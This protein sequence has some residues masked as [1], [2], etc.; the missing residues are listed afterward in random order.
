MT[1]PKTTF[2]KQFALL[3]AL[4]TAIALT[5]NAAEKPPENEGE[6][7]AVYLLKQL[8]EREQRAY[9]KYE[10][11]VEENDVNQ[12]RRELQSVIS[13]YERLINQSPQHAPTYVSYGLMLNRT[14]NRK[15][16]YAMFIKADELDPFLPVVKNQLGNYMAEE[17]KYAE[18]YGFFLLARDLDPGVSLYDYQIGNLL[19]GYRGYFIDDDFYSAPEIDL[20]IVEHFHVAMMNTPDDTAFRMRHAQSYFDIEYVN[21][22]EAL[23]AWQALYDKAGSEYEQQVVRLYTARVRFELGHHTAARKLLKKIDHP[24]LD[25]SKASIL[26]TIDRKYPQS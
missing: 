2:T 6:S 26:E 18:A 13:G 20:K 15:E 17:G 22:E 25:E 11:A 1:L 24:S 7:L 19:V 5:S 16:S 21:W 23:E 9:E 8:N 14:G 3:F 4:L 10:T 12:V